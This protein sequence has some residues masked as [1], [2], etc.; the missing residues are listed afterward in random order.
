MDSTSI[1]PHIT[2]KHVAVLEA[3]CVCLTFSRVTRVSEGCQIEQGL[4]VVMMTEE[5]KTELKC[6]AQNQGGRQEAVIQLQLEGELIDIV[7]LQ[8]Q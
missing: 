5:I 8:S 7:Y 1:L 3:S 2:C 4:A 6:V